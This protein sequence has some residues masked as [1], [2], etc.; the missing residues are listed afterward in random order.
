V[1]DVDSL[2]VEIDNLNDPLVGFCFIRSID[3][4]EWMDLS[5][6]DWIRKTNIQVELFNLY[7]EEEE[8]WFQ[9]SHA[10]WLLHGDRNTLYFHRIANG[11]KKEKKLFIRWIMVGLLLRVLKTC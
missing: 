9:R 10:R 7:V 4:E 8:Y 3:M 1:G 6:A 5:R 2:H 11:R